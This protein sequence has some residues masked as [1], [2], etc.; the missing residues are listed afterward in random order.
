MS[1]LIFRLHKFGFAFIL[2]VL[3]SERKTAKWLHG[4]HETTLQGGFCVSGTQFCLASCIFFHLLTAKYLN[5]KIVLRAKFRLTFSF[6]V[7]FQ[8]FPHL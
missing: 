1:A 7:H 2:A 3:S 5:Q 6:F 4:L 8:W